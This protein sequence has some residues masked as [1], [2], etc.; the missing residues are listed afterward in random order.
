MMTASPRTRS[1]RSRPNGVPAL[2]EALLGDRE[3]RVALLARL[4]EEHRTDVEVAV[5]EELG[6]Q[7]GAVRVDVALVNG[8]LSGYEIKSDRDS[9]R[10]LVSQASLYNAVLDHATL[11]VGGRHARGAMKLIPAWWEVLEARQTSAGV[12]FIQRREGRQNPSRDRRVL[13]EL[14][15]REDVLALLASRGAARGFRSK[16]RREL[17]NRVCEYYD[18]NEIATAVRARLRQRPTRQVAQQ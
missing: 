14:L 10:R 2:G 4:R 9:L 5:V 17:W 12:S 3:I 15:W 8:F 11:V 1:A 13:A 6:L 18:V 7:R 16:C